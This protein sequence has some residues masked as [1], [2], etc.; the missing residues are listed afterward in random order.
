MTELVITCPNCHDV[1][2][3]EQINCG[4]FRHAILKKSGKQIHP[5]TSH[6]KCESLFNK[7]RIYGCGKPFRVVNKNG[8]FVS[9]LCDYD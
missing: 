3:I 4:I 5:H 8:E 2:I 7:K 6:D 1:V 9:E